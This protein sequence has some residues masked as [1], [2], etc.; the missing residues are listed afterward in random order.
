[1]DSIE[2]SSA[3]TILDR[4]G[5]VEDVSSGETNPA[6]DGDRIGHGSDVT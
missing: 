1:M 6:N 2:I 4:L 3:A 5:R